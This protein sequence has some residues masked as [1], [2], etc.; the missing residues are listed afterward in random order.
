MS[1]ASSSAPRPTSRCCCL[2]A[3]N[4]ECKTRWQSI[5][6]LLCVSS[7]QYSSG[8]RP[9]LLAAAQDG[10][11]QEGSPTPP[12]LPAWLLLPGDQQ[13]VPVLFVLLVLVLVFFFA[14]AAAHVFV[15]SATADAAGAKPA[16]TKVATFRR[17]EALEPALGAL[18][19]DQRAH[20]HAK[21]AKAQVVATV[22][23]RRLRFGGKDTPQV[24]AMN[25]EGPRRARK[26][27]RPHA[28]LR[29][30]SQFHQES[31]TPGRSR[32]RE[33]STEGTEH[34]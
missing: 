17:P 18:G 6:I 16:A 9:A 13:L 7:G 22:S 31:H 2:H 20:L 8:R 26:L 12:L 10:A 24:R 23:S 27:M 3:T 1:G 30:R 19:H 21:A 5:K 29:W 32:R 11:A 34:S 25:S 15:P 28:K 14:L 4:K 33:P